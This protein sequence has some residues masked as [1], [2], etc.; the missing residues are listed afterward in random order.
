[1]KGG[2]IRVSGGNLRGRRLEVPA[3][4]R[5]SEGKIKEALFSI[6][7]DR[8]SAASFLDLFAGSGAV[9]IEALSRGAL[10]ATFVEA[11]RPVSLALK[12]NLALLPREAWRVRM[13]EVETALVA[14]QRAGSRYELIFLDPPY[15]RTADESLLSA[16][17]AVLEE[18][19]RIAAE[20][21]SRSRLPLEI[22]PLIRIEAR[23]YG[24]STLTFY[25]RS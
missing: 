5:P 4:I 10:T 22:G 12:R 17:D 15:A 20:H 1:M 9:G 13:E 8:L 2:G 14:E 23:R 19:G 21:D 3:G 18:G 6:W 11:R 25:G 16:C 24:E 7:A